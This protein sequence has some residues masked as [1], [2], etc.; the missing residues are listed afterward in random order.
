MI[1]LATQKKKIKELASRLFQKNKYERILV[2]YLALAEEHPNDMRIRLK[3]AET[4][5]QSKDIANAIAAYRQVADHY[6]KENFILKAVAIYK[7][8]LKL[9]PTL[10]EINMKL[11]EL[12]KKLNML[13]DCVNQYR[14]VM[15]THATLGEK[16]KVIET[17]RQLVEID[18]SVSNRRKLAEIYHTHGLTKEAVEQYEILAH[19]FRKNKQYDNLLRIYELILP[20]KPQSRSLIKDVC[21]L[22]LR[23]QEPDNAVRTMERYKVDTEPEFTNIYEKAQQMKEALR[24]QGARG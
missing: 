2:D 3:I 18:P 7:N 19:E 22:Y 10:V 11:A 9:D 1:D 13:P 24:R 8:I 17:C 4:Y 6:E 23:R 20:H 14:I 21:I 5:F 16:E 15:E 12:Y